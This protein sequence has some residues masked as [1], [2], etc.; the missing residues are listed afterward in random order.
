MPPSGDV[1]PWVCTGSANLAAARTALPR[2]CIRP[3]A[4]AHADRPCRPRTGFRIEGQIRTHSPCQRLLAG[5]RGAVHAIRL[6]LRQRLRDL[7]RTSRGNPASAEAGV[8]AFSRSLGADEIRTH[9]DRPDM[10]VAFNATALAMHLPSLLD[11]DLLL[12]SSGMTLRLAKGADFAADP[13]RDES[14]DRVRL[15]EV[16]SPPMS[17]GQWRNTNRPANRPLAPETSGGRN[18]RPGPSSGIPTRSAGGYPRNASC[19]SALRRVT[20]ME[21]TGRSCR[22]AFCQPMHARAANGFDQPAWTVSLLPGARKSTA[23]WLISDRQ[24]KSGNPLLWQRGCGT[25]PR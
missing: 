23:N 22:R 4:P 9:G 18:R 10:L 2:N 19:A 6:R 12:D 25:P 7:S 15:P 14:P 21:G 1:G 8:S 11:G 5:D 24:A 20:S 16:T 3:E 13:R 17:S